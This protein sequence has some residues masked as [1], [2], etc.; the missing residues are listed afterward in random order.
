MAEQVLS[1]RLDISR[2]RKKVRKGCKR[3]NMV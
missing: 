2:K 3:V 1:G